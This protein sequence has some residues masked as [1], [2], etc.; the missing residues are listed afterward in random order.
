M[1]SWAKKEKKL[2]FFKNI[3]ASSLKSCLISL[4]CMILCNNF[5]IQDGGSPD[6]RLRL[7]CLRLNDGEKLWVSFKRCFKT[8]NF[9]GTYQKI[10]PYATKNLQ[11]I[12]PQYAIILR[13]KMLQKS[14]KHK[15]FLMAVYMIFKYSKRFPFAPSFNN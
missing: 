4:L 5:Q 14:C 9:Y 2:T 15:I 1:F 13:L 6:A 7:A 3:V 12:T 8:N 11:N 10:L